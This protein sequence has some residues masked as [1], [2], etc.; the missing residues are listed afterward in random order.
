M[1]LKELV[2]ENIHITTNAITT[3]QPKMT[4]SLVGDEMLSTTTLNAETTTVI[5]DI[6]TTTIDRSGKTDTIVNTEVADEIPSFTENQ[7]TETTTNDFFT[8]VSTTEQ[9]VTIFTDPVVTDYKLTTQS[10]KPFDIQNDTHLNLT[11]VQ[12]SL[13]PTTASPKP[14]VT[15]KTL[16]RFPDQEKSHQHLENSYVRF[17]DSEFS[18]QTQIPSSLDTRAVP[19][20]GVPNSYKQKQSEKPLV[21]RENVPSSDNT[22]IEYS[23][24][25]SVSNKAARWEFNRR[26]RD[27]HSSVFMLPPKWSPSAFQ[28]PL[29]LRF[30]RKHAFMDNNEFK[31]PTYYRS[32]PSDDFAYLFKF[33]Q[34]RI[35]R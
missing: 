33:K 17:P 26:N 4:T 1:L 16:V 8:T 15:T 35:R 14:E 11:S 34:K 32:I 25:D 10:P 13:E 24:T 30:S 28:K 27:K 9:T 23:D 31:N 19:D 6:D 29:V 18:Y 21:F 20:F 5:E 12:P 2:A 7:P 3:S 22:N